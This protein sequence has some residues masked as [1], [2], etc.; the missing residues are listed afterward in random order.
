MSKKTFLL[1]LAIAFALAAVV[2]TKMLGDKNTKDTTHTLS[3]PEYDS[4]S[5][6]EITD[7]QDSATLIRRENE[8]E[9]DGKLADKKKV[10]NIWDEMD[11][12]QT[13]GPV[14]RNPKLHAQFQTDE[15]NATAVSFFT[16]GKEPAL[17]IL[18]GKRT[19]RF[20]GQYIRFAGEDTVWELEKN[21]GFL[22]PANPSLWYDLSLVS[23]SPSEIS[24]ISFSFPSGTFT[25][26]K[27]GKSEEG[28]ELWTLSLREEKQD[29]KQED[30]MDFFFALN[31]L[32]ADRFADE[33]E[34]KEFRNKNPLYTIII[35]NATEETIQL[36]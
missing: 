9:I 1:L 26:S 24:S 14:A 19:T 11:K 31:P 17:K 29:I 23:L 16:K 13:N 6:I 22:V 35:T 3:L 20:S 28:S 10:Q 5:R 33:R 8:W 15:Q 12:L 25:L 18:L 21:V 34:Q 4:V 32:R 30:L 7:S 36:N 2:A 27:K